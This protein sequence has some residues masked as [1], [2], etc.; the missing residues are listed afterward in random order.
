MSKKDFQYWE[1]MWNEDIDR[2]LPI[3]KVKRIKNEL[4]RNKI[5]N[6]RGGLQGGGAT[7]SGLEGGHH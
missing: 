6:N 5:K 7:D 1:D 4:K 2:Q 3:K